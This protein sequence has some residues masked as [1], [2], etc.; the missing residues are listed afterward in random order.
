MQ[1]NTKRHPSS[2][3]PQKSAN[4]DAMMYPPR[5][6]RQMGKRT[7]VLLLNCVAY[8]MAA[9]AAEAA[10]AI[11][12]VVV[13]AMENTDAEKIYG[14]QHDAP[15]INT[16][17]LP[18]YA[19]AQNFEDEL[20]HDVPSE[21][22]YVWMEAGTGTFPDHEF[23]S[24][25]PPSAMNS[26]GSRD[27]LATQID[28][29]KGISWMTYQEGQNAT[30]GACPIVRS[31]SYRPRHNPF[32]FFQDIAGN[33][34]RKDNAA[35]AAHSKPYASFAADLAAN[36]VASYVFITPNL[37]HD[38]HDTCGAKSRIMAGD[39]WL[40]AELPR[41]I[42]WANNQ[43]G[44]IFITWDEGGS[45][46][47]IPFLAIGPGVKPNYASSVRFDHGSMVKSVE[48]IF[49]LPILS[50]VASENSLSDMFKA[51]FFP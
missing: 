19:R 24:D 25:A 3:V 7:L 10:S 34:P 8:L 29:A 48:Q 13:I 50:A 9:G 44:V 42:D 11:R 47:K 26:T 51:G 40:K 2:K 14:N 31:G 16:K 27:H 21:P 12:H 15:F 37:C 22:H 32:I 1:Q 35:C 5:K 36:S 18:K 33:P 39:N 46:N 28:H 4:L 20:A 49:R 17:L 6:H 41:I 23:T 45:T 43:H 38:M 30:T